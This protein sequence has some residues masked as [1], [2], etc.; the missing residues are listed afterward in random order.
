MKEDAFSLSNFVFRCMLSYSYYTLVMTAEEE[1]E[2][3]DEKIGDSE[4]LESILRKRIYDEYFLLSSNS[5]L[6]ACKE[7]EVSRTFCLLFLFLQSCKV[8]QK[9]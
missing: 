9:F 4:K 3:K 1:K 5:H 8:A 2:N 7:N 6:Y